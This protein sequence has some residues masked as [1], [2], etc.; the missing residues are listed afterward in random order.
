MTAGQLVII[1]AIGFLFVFS[2]G[3]LIA[4][5]NKAFDRDLEMRLSLLDEDEL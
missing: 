4:D 1:F 3:L 5:E 2:I